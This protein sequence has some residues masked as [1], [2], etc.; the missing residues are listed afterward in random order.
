MERLTALLGLGVFIAF[1]YLTSVNR[2]AV[3]WQPVL[4]GFALQIIF[5]LLILRTAAG[6]A[7]FQWLGNAVSTFLDYSDAGASFVFGENYQDFFF[8]FKV[9]PT[10]IFFSAVISLLYHYGI[11][12]R[13]VNLIAQ[14]MMRTMKTSGS[15]TLSAAGN[16][17]VGQTEAPLLIKP[18]VD[19]MTMS[20]LHAVM[21]GGFATIAGGVLAAYVSFGV[22][23]EH[24]IAASVM[25]APAALAISK[26]MFPETETSPTQGKVSI[27][28]ERSSANGIDAMATGALDGLRLALNVGAIIIAFLGVLAAL[29]AFIGFVGGLVG[30]PGLS[31]EVILAA[32]LA[33]I[34]WLMGVPWADC[35]AVG[36]LLGKKTILNEFI[37]YLDLQA[38]IEQESIS[39][40]AIIIATYALCGFANIGSIG[41]QIGGIGGIAPNR[42]GDL[43]KIGVRAMVAGTLACFTTACIA[44][45]LL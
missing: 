30:F 41:I 16:I 26:I 24:L 45:M 33:P 39:E 44:G 38:L 17:F 2:K 10:I 20:E 12:Q 23:A 37:A 8:A 19:S 7:V 1:A 5:A 6:L 28:V 43:A 29:N 9:L 42:Q 18:Y 25:S 3:R 40:R 32:L 4:W 31:L 15:E 34:A 22:P 36:T 13:A 11:L 35:S 27:P 21:T 14:L